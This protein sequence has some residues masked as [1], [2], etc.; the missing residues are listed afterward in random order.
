[1]LLMVS[2]PRDFFW[3]PKVEP[4]SEEVASATTAALLLLVAKKELG[5]ET[6]PEPA[7]TNP[8]GGGVGG[9]VVPPNKWSRM[10]WPSV[11]TM[12]WCPF[13]RAGLE[14]VAVVVL[15]GGVV[16]PVPVGGGGGGAWLVLKLFWLLAWTW[17]VAC[18]YLMEPNP[19]IV[20]S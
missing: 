4:E 19:D 20:C 14:L 3:E 9:D 6:I 18:L 12:K 15:A 11:T 10:T 16:L 13:R 7:G 2:G 1:M 8:A 17:E 5:I